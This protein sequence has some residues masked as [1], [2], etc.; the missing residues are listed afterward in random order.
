MG[1]NVTL[2]NQPFLSN[3]CSV[4][5]IFNNF[6]LLFDTFCN[7]FKNLLLNPSLPPY[8]YEETIALYGLD[9]PLSVRLQKYIVNFFKGDLGWSIFNFQRQQ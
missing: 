5:S 3:G 4:F 8:A 6:Y 1:E 2:Y 7:A 9:Q